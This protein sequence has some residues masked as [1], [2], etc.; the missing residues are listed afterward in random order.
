MKYS[1]YLRDLQVNKD[2][3]EA[4]QEL[5]INFSFARAVVRGRIKRGWSQTRLA[6]EVGTRQANISR[7]E[8]GQGNP[9]LNL[10]KRLAKV[11][12]LKVRF[13]EPYPVSVGKPFLFSTNA[14]TSPQPSL[15][16][17][18]DGH[19]YYEQADIEALSK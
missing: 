3:R 11:L 10:I 7:I 2:Y 6:K 12:D 16:F 15:G 9:T 4:T 19:I 14:T 5:E 13:E 8:S 1:D 18:M 17:L